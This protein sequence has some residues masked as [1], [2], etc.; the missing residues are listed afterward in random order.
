MH[1]ATLKS[2]IVALQSL[3]PAEIM[4]FAKSLPGVEQHWFLTLGG[5]N[6]CLFFSH[7]SSVF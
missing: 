2:G 5:Y 6:S 4:Q 3:I 1:T 7:S